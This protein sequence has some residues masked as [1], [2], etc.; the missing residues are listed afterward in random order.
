MKKILSYIT[1]L[2]LATTALVSCSAGDFVVNADAPPASDMVT[3]ERAII[4][5][6]MIFGIIYT[7]TIRKR[8]MK[9][10]KKS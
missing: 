9:E 1:A 5:S 2:L 3:D 6:G 10:E 7:T 4:I 8:L